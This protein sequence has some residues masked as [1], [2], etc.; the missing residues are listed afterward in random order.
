ML[1][2]YRDNKI[3]VKN[4]GEIKKELDLDGTYLYMGSLPL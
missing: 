2:C 3:F 1:L 4:G